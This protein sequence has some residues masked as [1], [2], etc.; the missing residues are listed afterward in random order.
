MPITEG[1][2]DNAAP[3]M[4]QIDS[5]ALAGALVSGLKQAGVVGTQQSSN[6][7]EKS[8]FQE[9]LDF[10]KSNPES[11]EAS[12]AGIKA[13]FDGYTKDIEKSLT[14]KQRD[15]MWQVVAAERNRATI[16][17]IYGILES[18]FDDDEYLAENKDFLKDK[19]VHRFDNDAA[20]ATI[21]ERY[22]RG[23]V[24]IAA[25]K[26]LA[27]EEI[28]KF[29]KA[30]GKDVI[31]AKS[32]SGSKTES[33]KDAA[34]AVGESEKTESGAILKPDSLTPQERD[35]YYARLGT[36]Q[37]LGLKHDSED[38]LKLASEAVI[39]LR[40][41]KAKAKAAGLR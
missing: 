10:L 14:A 12:L 39:E 5:A 36:A 35:L 19:I 34:A 24:D 33:V 1:T 9:A 11:D 22:A 3:Q 23:D 2:A 16:S 8:A 27:I 41:G 18:H 40:K 25:I 4:V 13:L 30:R 21:R 31:N 32:S 28:N 17:T 7:Q 26:K 20:L 29:N 6:T 15:E 38:A 37:R